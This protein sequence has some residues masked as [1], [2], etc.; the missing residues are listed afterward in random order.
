MVSPE[1]PPTTIDN[2][3]SQVDEKLGEPPQSYHADSETLLTKDFGF[4]PIPRRLHYDPNKPFHFGLALNIGFGFASAFS[5]YFPLYSA[6]DGSS[7]TALTIVAANLY[8]CQPLLSK[9]VFSG[10]Q[11]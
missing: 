6:F 7:I 5:G 10:I 11:G 9:L 4:I 8:Y 1:S 2:P 3:A